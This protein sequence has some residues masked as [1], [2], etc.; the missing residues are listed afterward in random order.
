MDVLMVYAHEGP[1]SLNGA[2]RA[3]K[4]ISEAPTTG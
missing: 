2:N 4:R 3:V 1:E